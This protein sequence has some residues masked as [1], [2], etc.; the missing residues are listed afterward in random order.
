MGWSASVGISVFAGAGWADCRPALRAAPGA[1]AGL[2]SGFVG[3]MSLL[4]TGLT[5]L[6]PV[7]SPATVI[8]SGLLDAGL[9]GRLAG[10]AAA[11]VGDLVAFTA[12]RFGVGLTAV[13]GDGTDA[14]SD[15]VCGVS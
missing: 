7:P 1:A 2:R 12:T 14:G 6:V 15:V 11:L 13:S 3:C 5:L 9:A 8:L 10:V 4:R